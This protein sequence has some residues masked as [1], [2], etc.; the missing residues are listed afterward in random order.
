MACQKVISC[1]FCN[2]PVACHGHKGIKSCDSCGESYDGSPRVKY[3]V[4]NLCHS[5]L[6][7]ELNISRKIKMVREADS[8]KF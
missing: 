8:S 3:A 5:E 7:L 2:D 6:P 1:Y 4:C